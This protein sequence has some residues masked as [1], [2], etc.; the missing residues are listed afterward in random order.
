MRDFD[1]PAPE[2]E[3]RA[4]ALDPD[5]WCSS[6]SEGGAYELRYR[7]ERARLTA[8]ILLRLPAQGDV[9]YAIANGLRTAGFKVTTTEV[10]KHLRGMAK[11]GQVVEADS[12]YRTGN[13]LWW[14]AA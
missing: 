2:I 12:P 3:V 4:E 5:A 13:M 11:A 9:T 7:R 14:R 6:D 1:L 10:R 8:A